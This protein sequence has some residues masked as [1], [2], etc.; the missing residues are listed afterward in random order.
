MFIAVGFNNGFKIFAILNDQL[1]PLKEVNLTNCKILKYSHGGHY[2]VT[3]EKNA[4]I[5][6]DTIYYEAT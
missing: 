3:N 2:L 1:Y 4:I 5:I 6:Y